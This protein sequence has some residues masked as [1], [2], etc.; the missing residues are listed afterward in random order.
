MTRVLLT[1]SAGFI[2]QNVLTLLANNPEY[3]VWALDLHNRYTV[4]KEIWKAPNVSIRVGDAGTTTLIA[5]IKPDWIIHLAGSA[6]VRESDARPLDYID[7]NVRVTTYVFEQARLHGVSRVVY[8]SSSSV[9]GDREPGT[10]FVESDASV[11]SATS[12][13]GMTKQMCE[14]IAQY[15]WTRHGLQSVGLRFFTVYGPYGRRNMAIRK[16]TERIAAHQPIVVFGDGEQTRDFTHVFDIT[17]AIVKSCKSPRVTA[18]VY[19]VGAG[20]A[21][22]V[23][24][25]VKK[26]STA[27]DT[28]AVVTYEPRHPAD[29]PATLADTLAIK[30]D[31]GFTP[32]ISLDEG[33][34][35]FIEWWKNHGDVEPVQVG[36]INSPNPNSE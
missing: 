28:E 6:G 9:Y 18:N 33:L 31:L 20:D 29:V 10:R 17:A 36:V 26:I 19:N 23:N 16:F 25:L 21:H 24:E 7:N 1:G 11:G 4:P 32:L 14:R 13:Y 8:A 35:Q 27:L 12:V 22:T 3:H 15:Y 34:K 2:G 30:R 5:D